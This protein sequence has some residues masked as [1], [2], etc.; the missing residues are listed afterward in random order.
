MEVGVDSGNQLF[1]LFDFELNPRLGKRV[2]VL[3]A[4]Q[5]LGQ[6]PKRVGLDLVPLFL[7]DHLGD[8]QVVAENDVKGRR[9]VFS[10]K[11]VV[12]KDQEERRH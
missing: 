4:V 10:A 7:A 5:D 3:D 8:V 12:Q 9:R 1:Q 11:G 2:I 6:A